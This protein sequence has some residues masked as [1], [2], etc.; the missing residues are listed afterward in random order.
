MRRNQG[1]G[2]HLWPEKGVQEAML[3]GKHAVLKPYCATWPGP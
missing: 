1:A 3:S 2:P